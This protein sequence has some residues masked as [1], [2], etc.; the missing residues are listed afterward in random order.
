MAQ[1]YKVS[2]WNGT[3]LVAV[4]ENIV[5]CGNRDAHDKGLKALASRYPVKAEVAALYNAQFKP[6]LK[7]CGVDGLRVL[8]H[9]EPPG[10]AVG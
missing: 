7:G 3:Q 1:L 10:V 4:A 6:W 8:V 5:A 9:P 2:V